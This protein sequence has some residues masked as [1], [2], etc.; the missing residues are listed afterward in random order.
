MVARLSI[1]LESLEEPRQSRWPLHFERSLRSRIA[2]S[3]FFPFLL[4]HK[5]G[6]KRDGRQKTRDNL[7]TKE[8]VRIKR[9]RPWRNYAKVG[10]RFLSIPLS[11]IRID[12]DII[13]DISVINI[14]RVAYS[15]VNFI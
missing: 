12:V 10:L 13:V 5:L 15:H 7:S 8:I 3:S 4:L 11:G 1:S 2:A 9:N 14:E 6:E